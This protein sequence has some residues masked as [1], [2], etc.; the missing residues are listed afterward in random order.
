[1]R[2]DKTGVVRPAVKGVKLSLFKVD[3]PQRPIEEHSLVLG[4]QGS[5]TQVPSSE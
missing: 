1:M 2:D 4:D 5:S 3:D